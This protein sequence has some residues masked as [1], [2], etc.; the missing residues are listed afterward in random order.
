MS[1][2]ATI[3]IAAWVGAAALFVGSVA[4]A[5]FAVLPDRALAGALVGRVLPVV[6]ITGIVGGALTILLDWPYGRVASD[7]WRFGAAVVTAAACA[8][9]QFVVSPRIA[10]L[11]AE[12]G[13]SLQAIALDDPRRQAFGQLHAISVGWL[14]VAMLAAT[15]VVIAGAYALRGP[16]QPS[17]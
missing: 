15:V 3:L 17:F 6:F 8:V 11:R 9:A 16:R 7:K 12:I 1:R 5:A 13:P 14:G 2:L 10:S 4:P